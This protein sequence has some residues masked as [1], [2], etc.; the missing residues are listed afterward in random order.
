MVLLFLAGTTGTARGR[1]AIDRRK[2]KDK[3]GLRM[4]IKD[5]TFLVVC[6][7][8][9]RGIRVYMS[10]CISYALVLQLLRRGH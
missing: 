10:V 1:L 6:S 8:S 4:E 7:I 2:S 3:H 5:L 9:P